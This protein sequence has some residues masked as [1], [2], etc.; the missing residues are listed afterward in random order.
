MKERSGHVAAA[1]RRRRRRNGTEQAEV[2]QSADN[3]EIKAAILS[4][5]GAAAEAER[6]A[7]RA[8]TDAS[9]VNDGGA[10]IAKATGRKGTVPRWPEPAPLGGALPPVEPFSE[11]LLPDSLRALVADTAERMQIPPD[12]PGAFTVLCLAGCVNRRANIQPKARDHILDC[13]AQPLGRCN[14]A[15]WLLEVVCHESLHPTLGKNRSRL[16][17]EI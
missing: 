3:H 4:D 12:I 15:A 8:R 17:R 9:A 7:G 1:G 6:M 11:A 10:R 16:A 14:R 5:P 2:G 13:R